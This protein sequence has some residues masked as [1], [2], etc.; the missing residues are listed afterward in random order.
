MN[1][2]TRIPRTYHRFS[3]LMAQLLR[4]EKIKSPDT[5][6]YLLRVIKGPVTEHLPEDCLKVAA[7]TK[8]RLVRVADYVKAIDQNRPIV[9]VIGA[10][11]KGNPTMEVGYTQDAVCISKYPL[12]AAYAVT[13]LLIAFE[14][15]WGII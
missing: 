9:F 10:V 5:N 3:P 2:L 4:K 1:P 6:E 15:L 12:T 8:G 13:K 11:A 14:T 7:S